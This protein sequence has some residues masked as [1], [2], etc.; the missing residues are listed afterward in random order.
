MPKSRK[1][2]A[3]KA[4]R[5]LQPSPATQAAAT[6]AAVPETPDV[7]RRQDRGKAEERQLSRRRDEEE[8]VATGSV[9]HV[10]ESLT[11]GGETRAHLGNVY[12]NVTNIY[13]PKN[14]LVSSQNEHFF[15]KEKLP[16]EEAPRREEAR[17]GESRGLGEAR[18]EKVL[19]SL[20]FD[21]MGSRLATIRWPHVRT[22]SWLIET[23][24]YV[25]WQ[26]R[27]RRCVHHGVL[28]I[29]GNPGSGKSTLMKH[30]LGVAEK[31]DSDSII[32]S[33]FFN[34]RG[35]PLEKSTEGMYRSLLYQLLNKLP[36]IRPSQVHTKQ[37][38]WPIEALENMFVTTL[39]SIR[40]GEHIVLY[41]DGLDECREAEARDSIAFFEELCERAIHEDINLSICLSSR[42]YPQI[43]MSKH[44]E[45]I[46]DGRTDHMEDISKYV[47]SSL[48]GL[49]V[50]NYVECR[51]QED[52]QRR[53]SG[54]FLWVVLVIKVLK[55]KCDKGAPHSELLESLQAVPDKLQDFFASI[56]DE[57]DDELTAAFQWVLFSKRP[58]NPEELY[59]AI[60]TGTGSLSTGAWDK[61]DSDLE[62][63]KL[64]ILRSSRGL[65]ETVVDPDIQND[66]TRDDARHFK[67]TGRTQ[68]VHESLR[69]HLLKGGL[70]WLTM[71]SQSTPEAFAHANLAQWC[72]TYLQLDSDQYI[73][74]A[75]RYGSSW[76]GDYPLLEYAVIGLYHH[77]ELA[78]EK[79]AFR[80]EDLTRLPL[81]LLVC[82][83]NCIGS[84]IL[85]ES[86]NLL[87]LLLRYRCRNLA[88]A[89]L[90]HRAKMKESNASTL[91]LPEDPNVM[92]DINASDG[93]PDAS[94][95][96]TAEALGDVEVVQLL[97]DNDA[98]SS[99]RKEIDSFGC[100]SGEVMI[101]LPW[102]PNW[103][104]DVDFSTPAHNAFT[105]HRASRP[106]R[107]LSSEDQTNMVVA[108]DGRR[109][110][111]WGPFVT[112]HIS[113]P[114]SPLPPFVEQDH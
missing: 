18:R 94:A 91:G 5:S 49:K 106:S 74:W 2:R 69:E 107:R 105:A 17:F 66:Y 24:E 87:H 29:K 100:S 59:F 22:C 73:H 15:K 80:I 23:A 109:N 104:D 57:P 81:G 45:L 95:L 21:T 42:H 54:V 108:Q 34:A 48:R 70:A 62:S 89:L 40:S 19:E 32:V 88:K 16:A 101:N 75:S 110:A 12:G 78:C 61:L 14:S 41:I 114:S 60:R 3:Q 90:T 99:N 37:Q 56:L 64:F 85:A 113:P 84:P 35:H 103:R 92:F 65:I 71:N 50:T 44:E 9:G 68:F 11:L 25:S 76:R 39:L 53:C 83:Y 47:Q 27:E 111:V 26:K 58:L 13:G 33:F 79:G 8:R 52:I 6:V 77:L 55:E 10:F 43:T 72:L 67:H 102:C 36:Y 7:P 112:R 63:M 93:G 86:A 51:I 20:Q 96:I 46:I 4:S 1:K 28:W 30:A 38:I 97:L 98:D 31:R 82:S